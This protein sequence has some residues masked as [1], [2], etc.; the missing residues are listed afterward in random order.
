M[1]KIRKLMLNLSLLV[2]L[3]L[4]LAG[5]N[6]LRLS[7]K[8]AALFAGNN[9]Y[10]TQA[11]A[12]IVAY[13]GEYAAVLVEQKKDAACYVVK[14]KYGF[15]WKAAGYG[16]QPVNINE[17]DDM[18]SL[19]QEC[20]YWL[21]QASDPISYDVR[22]PIQYMNVS[23]LDIK[24]KLYSFYAITPK[25]ISEYHRLRNEFFTSTESFNAYLDNDLKVLEVLHSSG[26]NELSFLDP[27][28]AN[29]SVYRNDEGLNIYITTQVNPNRNMT[30]QEV[31]LESQFI[32]NEVVKQ[33]EA[34]TTIEA[35][36][37]VEWQMII[38]D[39]LDKEKIFENNKLRLE[40]GSVSVHPF[41]VSNASNSIDKYDDIEGF[42]REEGWETFK[43]L[44][45]VNE[46]SRMTKN[47]MFKLLNIADTNVLIHAQDDQYLRFLKADRL[48]LISETIDQTSVFIGFY[49]NAES[50]LKRIVE[51]REYQDRFTSIILEAYVPIQS[52]EDMLTYQTTLIER[53]AE[54]FDV[55]ASLIDV[56]IV[57]MYSY[58]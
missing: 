33:L 4:F 15:L 42:A 51:S 50:E 8:S 57:S 38:D 2:L 17:I 46:L 19:K 47:D 39:I 25:E 29:T 44:L 6:G 34:Y 23:D 27:R 12:S 54:E 55:N 32:L 37:W 53:I 10:F 58:K 16:I 40:F 52:H 3:I 14:Q 11:L 13:E 30:I 45:T 9:H 36:N 31:Y 48:P 20:L 5:I 35:M 26:Q 18:N 56:A 24:D 49:F 41:L 28:Q 7:A 43:T 1:S 22:K 21:A